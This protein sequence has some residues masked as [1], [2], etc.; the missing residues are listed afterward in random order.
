MPSYKKRLKKYFGFSKFRKNQKK[1]IN[2]VLKDNKD[3]CAIMFTGAG[4]SLCYQFPAVFSKKTV[5]VISPLISLMNDQNIKLENSNIKSVCLNSTVSDKNKIKNKILKNKYRLVYTTPEY[6]INQEEFLLELYNEGNLLMIAVD[7]SHCVSSWG[8]DFRPSYKEI[9]KIK[10]LLPDLPLMALTATATPKVQ[11]DMIDILRLNNPYIVKT[12]FDR[13]NLQIRLYPKDKIITDLLPLVSDNKTCIIYC[14]TRKDTEKISEK[15]SKKGIKCDAYHA[16]LP[17]VQRDIIQEDFIYDNIT[18]IVATIAFGMGIDKTV[19]RVIHYGVSKDMESYYQEIGR[20]G[21]DG[22]DAECILFYSSKDFNTSS[23]FI[24]KIENITYR[25]HKMDLLSVMKKFVYSNLCRR[26]IILEYFGEKYDKENCKMCDNCLDNEESIKVDFTFN[27]ILLLDTVYKTGNM[28]GMNSIINILRGCKRKNILKF[29]LFPFYGKGSKYSEKWWKIFFR[30]IINLGFLKEKAISKGHGTSIY[31]T[32]EGYNF[33]KKICIDVNKLQLK[34][35]YEK[36]ILPIPEE[37]KEFYQIK[38]V[39]NNSIEENQLFKLILELRKDI[40][41]RENIKPELIFSDKTLY[42]IVEEKPLDKESFLKIDGVDEL[43][44]YKYGKDF[45]DLIITL[46]DFFDDNVEIKQKE[47]RDTKEITYEL[48]QKEKKS[49]KD[50]SLLRSIQ[51]RTVEDHL[52]SLF[53]KSYKLDLD[54]LGFNDDIYSTIK[55]VILENKELT[56]LRSIK[57]KLPKKISYLHIKLT[58]VKINL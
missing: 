19:R 33:L 39:V 56:K 26:Q 30:M 25:N 43:R 37:M 58:L 22:L 1:I 4:K 29:K 55:N 47:K 17:S 23:Y 46:N 2:A 13:P 7:E 10:L 52:V 9:Q 53:K 18:C 35:N 27:T 38:P 12:T 31:R 50:I 44:C 15:L 40:A 6:I 36:L 20:A 14:Q 57:D 51:T 3:V 48:F 45:I 32:N 28:F 24:N 21:R 54:R 41:K 34:D 42:K 5:I 16:G 11:K 49:V 8:H